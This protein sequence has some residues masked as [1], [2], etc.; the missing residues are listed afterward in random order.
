[1][2]HNR[3]SDGRCSSGVV[4]LNTLSVILAIL[5]LPLAFLAPMMVGM[6]SGAAGRRLL[7]AE[8]T[9]FLMMFYPLVTAAGVFLSIRFA[10]SHR[11]IASLWSAIVPLCVAAVLIALAIH[12]WDAPFD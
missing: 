12:Y 10:R 1:M 9:G 4:L 2:S 11:H 7:S 8:F 3:A 6:T 5:D